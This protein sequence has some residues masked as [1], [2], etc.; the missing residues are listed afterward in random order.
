MEWKTGKPQETGEYLVRW[1]NNSK[2]FK[3]FDH[4]NTL[5]GYDSE[6]KEWRNWKE[7]GLTILAWIKIPEYKGGK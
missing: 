3:N 1:K 6:K 7:T 4:G 5:C 2:R